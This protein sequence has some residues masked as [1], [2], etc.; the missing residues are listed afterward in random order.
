MHAK[1]ADTLVENILGT[2]AIKMISH[3]VEERRT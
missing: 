2:A 3:S 1:S